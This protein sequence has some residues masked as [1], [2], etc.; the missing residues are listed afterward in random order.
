MIYVV[1]I[2]DTIREARVFLLGLEEAARCVV[3][4]HM[5]E[6][7]TKYLFVNKWIASSEHDCLV[8]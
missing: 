4:L 8:S 5:N 2:T 6:G 7:K 3:G 1:L